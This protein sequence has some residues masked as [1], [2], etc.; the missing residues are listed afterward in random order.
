MVNL[1]LKEGGYQR[2]EYSGKCQQQL[3]FRLGFVGPFS[4]CSTL[5]GNS[6]DS[7]WLNHQSRHRN[8][9]L[10]STSSGSW[11][12]QPWWTRSAARRRKITKK[13][14]RLICYETPVWLVTFNLIGQFDWRTTRSDV[15]GN[16]AAAACIARAL[17]GSWLEQF[18]TTEPQRRSRVFQRMRQRERH[19]SH[20]VWQM[21]VLLNE[22]K[23]DLW[24]RQCVL[25]IKFRRH[26]TCFVQGVPAPA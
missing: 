7:F 12:S 9:N 17:S 10:A 4:C 2:T 15:F 21:L 23:R 25:L 20:T 14:Q 5:L 13:T 6:A 26:W 3:K 18:V 19:A 22:I 1:E 24:R 16:L 11:R 8:R